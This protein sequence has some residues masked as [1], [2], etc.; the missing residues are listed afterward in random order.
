MWHSFDGPFILAP[1]QAEVFRAAASF[2]SD[3][4]W[5]GN[6]IDT[7]ETGIPV[8]DSL[9]QGQ[10][11][12][13]ILMV[14]GALLDPKIQPPQINAALAGTVHAVFCQLEALVEIEAESGDETEMRQM[15]LDAVAETGHWQ[16][17]SDGEV[18]LSVDSQQFPTH[19]KLR[20]FPAVLV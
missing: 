1:K 7:Y 2:L 14:A 16:E 6:G 13:A 4:V 20:Y 19:Q 3:L 10:K 8:F 5:E 11:Q 12:F 17:I 18:I 15:V 9:S